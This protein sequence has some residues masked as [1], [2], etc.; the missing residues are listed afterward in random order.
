MPSDPL[1]HY[2][3]NQPTLYDIYR[4]LGELSTAAKEM[5]LNQEAFKAQFI[6]QDERISKVEQNWAKIL[7]ASVIISLFVTFIAN[8]IKFH[9]TQ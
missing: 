3:N 4:E 5:L 6:K 9:I 8:T 1:P 7:G 2:D